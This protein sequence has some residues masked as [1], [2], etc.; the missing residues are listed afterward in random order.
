MITIL[1]LTTAF[2]LLAEKCLAYQSSTTGHGLIPINPGEAV[3]IAFFEPQYFPIHQWTIGPST[4]EHQ[5]T[6]GNQGLNSTRIEV[7]G[8]AHGLSVMQNSLLGATFQWLR[9]PVAGIGITMEKQVEANVGDYDNLIVAAMLPKNASLEVR[10]QTDKGEKSKKFNRLPGYKREYVMPLDGVSELR[11]IRMTV[12]C[13]AGGSRSGHFL[14]AGVQHEARLQ[15]YLENLNPFGTEWKYHLQPKKFSPSYRS[16]YG[17]V[18]SEE[19]LAALRRSHKQF[20]AEHNTSPLLKAASKAM[21]NPPEKRISDSIG[22]NIRFARDR[23]LGRA[24]TAPG[25]KLALA[26]LV[27]KNKEMLRMAARYALS[28]AI[29]PNWDESFFAHFPGSAWD[30]RAFRENSTANAVA[31]IL[32]L[33]GEMFTEAGVQF[34]QRRLAEEAIG[35]INFNTWKYEYIHHMNQLAAFSDGRILAYA[36]LEK[37]MARLRPYLEIAYQE[38]YDSFEEIIL[39][40][41]GYVEGPHY[42]AYAMERG[43]QAF[44][45]YA[46]ARNKTLADVMPPNVQQTT[47]FAEAVSST[48]PEHEVIPICDAKPNLGSMPLSILAAMKPDSRWTTLYHQAKK[49]QGGMPDELLPLILDSRIPGSAPPPKAFVHLPDMGVMASTRYLQGEPLKILLMGNQKDARHTHEDKGS[50]VLEFAGEIFAMDMGTPKFGDPLASIAKHCQ[51]HNM[52]VPIDESSRPAPQN[53]LPYDVKPKGIGDETAFKASIDVTP[54]W[55]EYYKKWQRSWISPSADRLTIRDRY[56]L[57]K[58]DGVEFYW[59]TELP[60]IVTGRKVSIEGIKGRVNIRVPSGCRVR[61]DKLPLPGGKVQNRIAI[62]NP[63]SSDDMKVDVRF[64]PK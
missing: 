46:R 62:I 2:N 19:D 24:F 58:G 34:L 4:S 57:K 43:G 41:G 26:G 5:E 28:M 36:I 27:T 44:Y 50:F 16:K 31:V 23:D 55:N 52:L 39:P 61:L 30:H 18:I 21:L 48:K 56:E 45:Y 53:P 33:A 42:L 47:S 8:S 7:A 25:S 14:W 11:H 6:L 38:L 59:L 32:D 20:V 22:N 1:L 54:G 10:I 29:T 60:A 17:I 35:F 49:R 13:E 9:K 40:D 64:Q 37:S 3:V 51:R 12:R 63:K 15:S